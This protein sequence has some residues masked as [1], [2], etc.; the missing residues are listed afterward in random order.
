MY[1]THL[2]FSGRWRSSQWLQTICVPWC[3]WRHSWGSRNVLLDPP[4]D[5]NTDT[6][7]S[8]LH[9]N[10]FR[11]H[12]NVNV[13]LTPEWL[14][15]LLSPVTGSSGGPS[16]LNWSEMGNAPET[17]DKKEKNEAPA[18]KFWIC[19]NLNTVHLYW[20]TNASLPATC[21]FPGVSVWNEKK[22]MEKS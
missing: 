22:M 3:R 12:S 6:F 17:E 8:L 18:E 20:V 21:Q 10:K 13:A 14:R 4:E 1:E 2:P 5:K 15:Y 16:G 19:H 9:C 7:S 11:T